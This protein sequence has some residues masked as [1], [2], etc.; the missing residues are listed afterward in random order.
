MNHEE[1]LRKLAIRDD[2]FVEWVLSHDREGAATAN[3]DPKT[4]ALVRLASLITI[5]AAPPS[6]TWAVESA[7]ESGATV[8]EIV[9]MLVALMPV[10]GVTRVVSAAPRLGLA[11]GYDVAE[12]LERLTPAAHD[13]YES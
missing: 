8:D 11:V 5:D 13:P 12:A 6:Y 3:L 10:I 9:G 4:F 7:Q 2:D 1:T